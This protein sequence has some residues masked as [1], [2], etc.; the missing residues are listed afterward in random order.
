MK[1]KIVTVLALLVCC[2][3]SAC[4]NAPS[5][6][7]TPSIEAA[8]PDVQAH[9]SRVTEVI[10]A[11]KYTYVL[12]ESGDETLWAAAP[13]VD[14]EVGDEVVLP[15]GMMAM[16][17]W[18]SKTLDR[19]WDVVYFAGRISKAGAAVPPPGHDR[20]IEESG[21]AAAVD[22]SAIAVPEG[23]KT[24][25]QLYE[26]SESLADQ[27]VVLRGIVVKVAN[28]IMGKNWVH[29]RDGSGEPGSDD[30]TVTTSDRPAVGN[31]VV[32]RG[33]LSTDVDFGAG[34]AFEVI[35]QDADLVVE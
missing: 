25:A 30:L 19:T 31:Q 13:S 27:P 10:Q 14:V 12:V 26:Q 2:S 34:Y 16:K 35:V 4:G 28:D 21:K 6:S 33:N 11:G 23:G 24:V 32:V 15:E 9:G 18:H 20:M 7:D 29:V 3:L 1:S 5:A 8:A 22:Y 17:D